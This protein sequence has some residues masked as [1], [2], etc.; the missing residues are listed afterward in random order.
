V[1][2]RPDDLRLCWLPLSHIYARTSDLYTWIASGSL[3]GLAKNRDT[4]LADCAMLHPTILHGVPYFYEKL[5]RTLT[6]QGKADEPGA[7]AKLL[8]GSIRPVRCWGRSA[9][10]PRSPF[11]PKAGSASP[12]RLWPHGVVSSNYVWHSDAH[13]IGTVGRPIPGVEV[14]IAADGEILT[15]GPHVMQGYWNKPEAT[16]DVDS[17]WMVTYRRPRPV[18]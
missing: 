15:R 6:D 14:R 16:A 13:R 5:C 4:I 3:L 7:L 8:G 10:R 12:S 17:R 1:S 18:G 2:C 11:F 9:A